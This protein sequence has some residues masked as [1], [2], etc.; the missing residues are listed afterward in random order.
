MP[1]ERLWRKLVR[2]ARCFALRMFARVTDGPV[3][4]TGA[5]C[6]ALTGVT[7]FAFADAFAVA[8][9][10][11]NARVGNACANYVTIPLARMKIPTLQSWRPYIVVSLDRHDGFAFAIAVARDVSTARANNACASHVTVTRLKIPMLQSWRPS[12]AVSLEISTARQSSAP[13]HICAHS[14]VGI[15]NGCAAAL[16]Q[17][18][19]A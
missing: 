18:A 8:R 17:H 7:V 2:T 12:I 4:W 1:R 16:R 14:K 9:D 13:A 15:C 10:V 3:T 5:A 19:L 11:N 6:R